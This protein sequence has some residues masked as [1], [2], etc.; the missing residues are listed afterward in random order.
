[1]HAL[2]SFI[3][4][5]PDFLVDIEIL[6]QEYYKF[7]DDKMTNPVRQVYASSI[8]KKFHLIKENISDPIIEQI[9]YTNSV[10]QKVKNIFIFNSVTFRLV[11]QNS[12]YDWHSDRGQICLHIPI[13]SN[14]GCFFAYEKLNFKM[15]ADGSAYL[16]NN[17]KMHTF[18]NSGPEPRVH[19]VFDK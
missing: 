12:C 15:P 19:I 1:M 11:M 7:I 6:Q 16:A 18:V 4:K 14:F 2:V 8:Q 10:L 13:I 17:S 9:P 5:V 3:D